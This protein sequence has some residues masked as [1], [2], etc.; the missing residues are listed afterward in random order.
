MIVSES[1]VFLL[2]FSQTVKKI[3]RMILGDVVIKG[4]QKERGLNCP[5]WDSFPN[6]YHYSS[7]ALPALAFCKEGAKHKQHQCVRRLI[8]SRIGNKRGK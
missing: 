2:S 1:S 5:F 8:Y 7:F 4:R 3:G 6:Y